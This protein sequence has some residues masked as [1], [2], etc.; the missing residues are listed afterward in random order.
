MEITVIVG[1][2]PE[3]IK[4]SPV[5]HAL[6]AREGVSVRVLLSGQHRELAEDALR[7][8]G[9]VPDAN[10]ALMR[11]GQTL[12]DTTQGILCRLPPLL[13][14]ARPQAVLVHGDTT[15]A[16]AAALACFYLGISVGHVEAGLRTYCHTRPYPEEFNRR[17]IAALAEWHFAPT[18]RARENLLREG[19]GRKKIFVVGNTVVDALRLT[20]RADYRHPALC[21]GER[22][23]FFTA[24]R[25]EMRE[26]ELRGILHALRCLVAANPDVSVLYPVHPRVKDLAHREL[27]GVPRIC[28]LPP[29]CTVDCH[30]LMARSYLIA[31]DSGGIQ[32]EA[33]ALG[34]PTLVLRS[35]TERPEG[36]EGGVLRLVGTEG[37]SFFRHASELLASS[38]AYAAMRCGKNPYGDGTAAEQIADALCCAGLQEQ[39]A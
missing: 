21:A 1:T 33:C 18:A 3:A 11:E 9:I 16:F 29:L 34:I 10:L 24:H 2:R 26:D 23:I 32:E 30:N 14:G 36:V 27:G 20:V 15:T 4:M 6:R 12:F 37:E 38:R 35:E 13:T 39:G 7:E 22:R 8:F 19:V 25:R 5:V 17:A 31:T 28:L